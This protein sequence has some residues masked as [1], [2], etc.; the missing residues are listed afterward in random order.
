VTSSRRTAVEELLH[1]PKVSNC[2]NTMHPARANFSN[3]C[4]G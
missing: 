4:L 2:Y 3:Y 1:Q